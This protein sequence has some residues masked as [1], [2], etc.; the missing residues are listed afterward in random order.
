MTPG[1]QIPA[2][3]MPGEHTCPQRPQLFASPDVFTHVPLHDVGNVL[4]QTQPPLVQ[5]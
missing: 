5:A 2:E 4:L 3:Q 1:W